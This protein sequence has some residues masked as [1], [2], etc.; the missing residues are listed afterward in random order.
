MTAAPDA[1]RARPEPAARSARPADTV[2][3]VLR[4]PRLLTRE[5]LAGVVTTLAL[6]PEVISFM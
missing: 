1:D 5:A 2:L 6:V 4:D 3:S